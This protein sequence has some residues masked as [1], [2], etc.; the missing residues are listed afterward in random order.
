MK[1]FLHF[2]Q[3]AFYQGKNAIHPIKPMEFS[4]CF[5]PSTTNTLTCLVQTNDVKPTHTSESL[6]PV[7]VS[8]SN[9]KWK[10]VNFTESSSGTLHQTASAACGNSNA[11]QCPARKPTITHKPLWPSLPAFQLVLTAA[12]QSQSQTLLTWGCGGR[13]LY[14]TGVWCPVSWKVK[15]FLHTFQVVTTNRLQMMF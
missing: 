4:E 8:D 9:H 3:K 7:A 1:I 13:H 15:I 6:C 10:E 5:S 11:A 14:I 12:L 2:S